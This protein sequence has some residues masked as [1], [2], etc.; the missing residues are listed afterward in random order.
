[1][2]ALIIM[3][4]CSHV[5]GNAC[6]QFEPEYLEFKNYHK[7]AIYGY[8]YSAELMGNFSDSFVEDFRPYIIFDCKEIAQT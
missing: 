7:C 3:Y 4:L 5:P 2:K 8:E 1:M 6:K